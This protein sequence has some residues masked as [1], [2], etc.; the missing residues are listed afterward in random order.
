MLSKAERRRVP[1]ELRLPI[2]EVMKRSTFVEVTQNWSNMHPDALALRTEEI[3]QVS[4]VQEGWAF[5]WS[6]TSPRRK[7]WFPINK[8]EF[9]ASSLLRIGKDEDA[10]LAPA[11]IDSLIDLIAAAVPGG[12]WRTLGWP[13]HRTGKGAPPVPEGEPAIRR[14]SCVE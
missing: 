13:P 14:W 10:P 1:K 6:L 11:A 4:L 7:G 5:G 3:V 12:N 9:I 8:S 2:N